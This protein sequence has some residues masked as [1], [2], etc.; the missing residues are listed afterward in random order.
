MS[1]AA[2]AVRNKRKKK[3]QQQQLSFISKAVIATPIL[4]PIEPVSFSQSQVSIPT[5]VLRL[6]EVTKHYCDD[7]CGILSCGR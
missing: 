5:S 4:N 2:I 3:Q 1:M 7:S 6:K